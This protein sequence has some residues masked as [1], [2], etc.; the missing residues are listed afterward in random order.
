MKRLFNLIVG[1]SIVLLYLFQFN[2]YNNYKE[3]KGT[4]IVQPVIIKVVDSVPEF[5]NKSP[6]E[7][8]YEALLYY[9][10]KHPDIVYAQAIHE[11]GNFTSNLCVNHNNLFGLYNSSKSRYYR[12]NHWTDAVVAYKNKIQ[13]RYTGNSNSPEE[14]YKFLRKIGYA[15]DPKYTSRIKK[16]TIQ[17]DKRR[18]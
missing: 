17:N 18:S 3:L 9:G 4:N 12:F 10:V 5:M 11:T 7:G 1:L 2:N 13:Y 8:L 14:Y 6:K 15:S 16:I